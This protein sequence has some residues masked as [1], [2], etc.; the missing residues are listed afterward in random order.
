MNEKL[1]HFSLPI[2]GCQVEG[3][4][5]ILILISEGRWILVDQEANNPNT[6]D[7]RGMDIE[8]LSLLH[9]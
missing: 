2:E 4:V 8:I 7:E 6:Q 9:M 1:Y 3:S 5:S